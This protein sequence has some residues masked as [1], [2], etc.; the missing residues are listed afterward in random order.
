MNFLKHLSP[1]SLGPGLRRD[2]RKKIVPFFAALALSACATPYI[3]PPLTP[4]PGF[5]GAHVEDRA[6]VM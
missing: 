1:K 2:E 3:Q 4:P 5:A 6:L